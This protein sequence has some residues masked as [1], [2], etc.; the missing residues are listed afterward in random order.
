[1]ELVLMMGLPGSG[2]STFYH[3]HL[4][5]S[6]ALVSK[7]AMR[8]KRNRD[9][10]QRVLLGEAEAAGR[11]VVLDNTHPSVESRRPWIGWGRERGRRVT[12]YYFSSVTADC[13]ERNALRTSEDKVPDVGFYAIVKQ[14]QLPRYDEGFDALYYV[15]QAEGKF[16][17]QDWR[18]DEDEPL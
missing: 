3:S 7:D 1:M 12:G 5:S 16:Q 14:L 6:H 9:R 18:E 4:S 15:S 2:K 11:S 8:G 10:E 13:Y 17:V